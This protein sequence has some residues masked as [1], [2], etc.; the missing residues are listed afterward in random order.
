MKRKSTSRHHVDIREARG[1]VLLPAVRIPSS[2]LSTLCGDMGRV[3]EY[4][5]VVG[6]L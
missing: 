3:I 5:P 1:L 6:G 2:S 4:A